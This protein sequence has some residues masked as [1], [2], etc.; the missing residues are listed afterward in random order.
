MKTVCFPLKEVCTQSVTRYFS[1][2]KNI[3]FACSD[4][5]KQLA[6]IKGPPSAIISYL[7]VLLFCTAATNRNQNTQDAKAFLH[8]EI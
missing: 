5:R 4:S 1:N 7:S 8:S 6:N 3:G 2:S